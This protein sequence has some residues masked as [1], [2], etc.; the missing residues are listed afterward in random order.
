MTRDRPDAAEL[1]EIARAALRES[2]LPELSG[3]AR[4]SALMVANAMAMA[5]RELQ[6]GAGLDRDARDD[7]ATLYGDDA[8]SADT[9]SA[10]AASAE[11]LPARLARDIRTGRFDTGAAA[12]RV[13]RLLLAD[14][15][16]RLAIG[17]PRYLEESDSGE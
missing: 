12:E 10:D 13:H 9:A 15:R 4:F 2:V 11:D 16:R 3:E 1:L 17:N 5:I 7:L 8:A 14:V 6:Q